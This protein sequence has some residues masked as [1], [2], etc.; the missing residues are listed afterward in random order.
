[1]RPIMKSVSIALLAARAEGQRERRELVRR[2]RRAVAEAGRHTELSMAHPAH[3]GASCSWRAAPS[4]L[5]GHARCD[6]GTVSPRRASDWLL[7]QYV[8]LI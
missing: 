3:H 8:R 6:D 1:M 4:R 2:M 7:L 5:R